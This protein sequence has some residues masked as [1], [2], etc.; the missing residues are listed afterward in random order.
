M[1]LSE[2]KCLQDEDSKYS[3]VPLDNKKYKI[4]IF[5]SFSNLRIEINSYFLPHVDFFYQMYQDMK[6][7]IPKHDQNAHTAL[8]TIYFI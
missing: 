3:L 6:I 8:E 4:L 7:L 5:L 1:S 2:E